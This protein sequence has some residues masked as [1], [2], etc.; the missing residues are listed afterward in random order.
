M[1]AR[2]F[3]RAAGASLALTLAC[4]GDESFAPDPS[5][6][7]AASID[8][9]VGDTVAV[10][11][12]GLDTLQQLIFRSTQAQTVAL[13]VQMDL[14]ALW[15][16]TRDSA[17][18]LGLDLH[19][20]DEDPVPSHLLGRRTPRITVSPG[21]VV[22]F[23]FMKGTGDLSAHGR[24]FL[25]KVNPAPEQ[26]SATLAPGDTVSGETLE[27]SAD[28]DEF[29]VSGAGAGSH[30]AFIRALGGYP[31]GSLGMRAVDLTGALL[32]LQT[33]TGSGVTDLEARSTG[34]FRVPANGAYRIRV[35]GAAEDS[36][37]FQLLSGGYQVSS[38]VI[39]PA[40]ESAPLTLT[41][42]DTLATER[43]DHVG[44][45]DRFLV[46]VVAGRP[47]NAFLQASPAGDSTAAF[48]LR[49]AME[50][51]TFAT[52]SAV[53]DT[54]LRHQFT[55][56]FRPSLTTNAVLEVTGASDFSSLDRGPYR[57]FVYPIDTLPELV[58]AAIAPGDTVT[59]ET[60]QY[61]GD[62]D[63]F[64]VT[65]AFDTLNILLGR[66]VSDPWPL[67]L[68]W[69]GPSGEVT[70]ACYSAGWTGPLKWCP[71]G[72]MSGGPAGIT[73]G[74]YSRAEG[75]ESYGSS[76]TLATIPL[77]TAPEGASPFLTYGTTV[78][79]AIEVPGDL[80]WYTFSYVRGTQ[81]DLVFDG[82][83]N[84]TDNSF[85][86]GVVDPSGAWL[87]LHVQMGI[88][89]G[90]FDL[91]AS[92]T[93]RVAVNGSNGGT[94]L[95][96][97]GPYTLQLK[98]FPTAPETAPASA[99]LGDSIVTEAIDQPGDIDDFVLSAQPGR[100]VQVVISRSL[101]AVEVWLPGDTIS[102]RGPSSFASGRFVMPPAGVV[103][104]RMAQ[105][106][107]WWITDINGFGVT[108]PYWFEIHGID[109]APES[110][111]PSVVLGVEVNTERIDNI[112]D[113]DEFSFAG[114][115]GQVVSLALD[116]NSSFSDLKVRL[117][118]IDPSTGQVI[119]SVAT[120]SQTPIQSSAFALPATRAYLVRAQSTDERVGRGSYR[121]TIQ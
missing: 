103:H 113:V 37:A 60:I 62:I 82:G 69:Q 111:P 110:A 26:A 106:R 79:A 36:W 45:I 109:R 64:T 33:A 83:G 22:Q 63:I 102:M 38:R 84:S 25:Y 92:G 20:L 66:G 117:E 47:Y 80:D 10:D 18:G 27:N 98:E 58:P 72:F 75:G 100:E 53:G 81:L 97:V 17:S 1:A 115:L 108:G 94:V 16:Y 32:G 88:P 7:S 99:T 120:T 29:A 74:V 2:I 114:S 8:I 12:T 59:T 119:G 76:Y 42:G 3:L 55:G 67:E 11:V 116:N 43:L 24:A 77:S 71:T 6:A 87:G 34:R 4:V 52:A 31:D 101:P 56:V 89:L 121:F 50:G 61:P 28:V 57:V 41:P 104:L 95:E 46:P 86:A 118:L 5:P 85:S 9:L 70:S 48:V 93:Y 14:G 40:P 51:D 96:E 15:I 54:T 105:P 73:A 44:D 78:N 13:F 35:Q 23:M 107:G 49:F 91:P 39:N 65:G 90:R 30:I 21:Q 112:G 19:L 68:R